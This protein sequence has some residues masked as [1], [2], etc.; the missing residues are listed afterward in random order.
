MRV[1]DG[2]LLIAIFLGF[3]AFLFVPDSAFDS[4]RYYQ[5]ADT[6]YSNMDLID[7]V[8]YC[9]DTYFDFIYYVLLSFVKKLGLPYHVVTGISVCVFYYQ[10]FLMVDLAR[11]KFDLTKGKVDGFI[12]TGFALI[13]VSY[14]VIF[15]ISRNL[16]A[17]AFLFTAINQ[18]LKGHKFKGILF[19]V[20]TLF[21]HFG[22]SVYVLLIVIAYRIKDSFFAKNKLR[23]RFLMIATIIGMAS[24]LWIIYIMD[25]ISVLPFFSSYS[26]YTKYLTLGLSNVFSAGLSLWDKLLFFSTAMVM[27]YALYH[28]TKINPLVKIV[29]VGYIWLA[30]SFGFSVMFTQRTLMY[31]VPFQAIVILSYYTSNRTK[32]TDAGLRFLLAFEL[33]VF[34]INVYT[35]RDMWVFEIPS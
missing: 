19:F 22:V 31:L 28:T 24:Y 6:T 10:S 35:Y 20:A 13:S 1:L 8:I 16:T 17:L 11:E 23:K 3:L 34:I 14:I 4:Y 30:V 29:F 2:R 21:T 32:S 15:A 5:D 9:Y 27:L 12:A 7:V 26:G 33:L 25:A 18:F